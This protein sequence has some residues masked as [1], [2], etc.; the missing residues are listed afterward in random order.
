MTLSLVYNKCPNIFFTRN[1]PYYSIS[2]VK[3]AIDDPFIV[4]IT[5][6]PLCL[7]PWFKRANHKYTKEWRDVLNLSEWKE[8]I[9][10]INLNKNFSILY[11]IVITI[12]NILLSNRYFSRS[13]AMYSKRMRELN[14]YRKMT[15][16]KNI[17]VK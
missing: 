8:D 3:K 5:G 4:H 6:H 12:I 13:I 17:S 14:K 7:R 2:D 15:T 1:E 9:K 16:P 10:Y 11:M